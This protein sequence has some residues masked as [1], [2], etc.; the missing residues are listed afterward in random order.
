MK[1]IEN[2]HQVD[3]KISGKMFFWPRM[4]STRVPYARENSFSHN[5]VAVATDNNTLSR[6]T[7]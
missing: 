1:S 6:W 2:K 5:S 4:H 3:R 7:A